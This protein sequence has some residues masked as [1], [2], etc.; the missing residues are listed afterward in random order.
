MIEAAAGERLSRQ[1]RAGARLFV[2]TWA[3]AL[4]LLGF[5]PRVTGMGRRELDLSGCTAVVSAG[6]AG[7]CRRGLRAGDAAPADHLRTLDHIA[8]VREKAS[9]ARE[10]VAAVDMETAWLAEAASTAGIPFLSV[11][12]II[13]GPDDPPL[14]IRTAAHYPLA[15]RRL[16]AAVAE[17]LSR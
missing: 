3:E 14:G 4:P 12:V 5:G 8:S 1:A 16:R 11:R 10:G 13:D 17:A 9:L 2:A 7:A 15:A 6:F